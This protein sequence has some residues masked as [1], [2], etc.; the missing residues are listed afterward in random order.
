LKP[1]LCGG[2]EKLLQ[3]DAVPADDEKPRFGITGTKRF[4]SRGLAAPAAFHLDRPDLCSAG[5]DE[6]NFVFPFPPIR[7]RIVRRMQGIDE[8]SP[9]RVL[10]QTPPPGRIRDGFIERAGRQG[11]DQGVVPEQQL[12]TAPPLPD[13]P[14]RKQLQWPQRCRKNR[15]AKLSDNPSWISS[16]D[17]PRTN[18]RNV[19]GCLSKRNIIYSMTE[20]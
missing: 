3:R 12:R 2:V 18:I 8:M 5:D 13:G 14:P 19:T 10:D 9:H 4:Q 15:P 20:Y 7:K 1:R 17:D 11:V 16:A 6:I